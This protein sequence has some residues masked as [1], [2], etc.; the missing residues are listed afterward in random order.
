MVSVQGVNILYVNMLQNQSGCSPHLSSHESTRGHNM[1]CMN[2]VLQQHMPR[3]PLNGYRFSCAPHP[4]FTI[5]SY[6]NDHFGHFLRKSRICRAS[7][8]IKGGGGVGSP[9]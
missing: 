1:L 4:I 5:L 2:K 8:W 7:Y 9:A 6:G 3:T